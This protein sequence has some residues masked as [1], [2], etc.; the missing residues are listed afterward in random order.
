MARRFFF[1]LVLPYLASP[2]VAASA[3]PE[4]GVEP[5][6]RL[7]AADADLVG[8]WRFEGDVSDAK[9]L[10]DG[11]SKPG[12]PQFVEGPGGG[13]AVLLGEKR[14][15]TMGPTPHLDVRKTTV[16]LWLKP[17]F[18]PGPGYNPCIVAKRAHGSNRG[19]RFSVH[20]WGDYS[21][22]AV[23]NGRTVLR[24]LAAG[25]PLRR[26][27][28]HHVAVTCDGRTVTM[29]VDGVPCKLEGSQDP[30]NFDH[31]GMP[32][33]IGSS[34]PEGQEWMDCSVDE[35]AVY[36]RAL[37]EEEIAAHVDAMG[38]RAKRLKLVQAHLEQIERDR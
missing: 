36:R 23:W 38:F 1:L 28:W 5:Y 4:A 27:A 30:F 19:T 21:C 24:F 8:Y 33:S 11:Q 9:G 25:G 26:G 17:T 18:E 14:F 22:L 35:V 10:A 16:E 13:Q 34:T 15:L 7:V 29:Y 6:T 31:T 2:A 12:E 3:P 32:L 20:V 37:S